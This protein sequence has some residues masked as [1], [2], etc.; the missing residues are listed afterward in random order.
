MAALPQLLHLERVGKDYAKLS[1]D[2]QR[3]RLVAD[4]LWGRQPSRHFRALDDVSL[5]L[6]AGE[7]LAI[8]GEN[9]AGKSTLLKIV[10]GVITPTRGSVALQG[11]VSA[12]LELG[13]GFHPEYSG[14]DNIELAATLLGLSPQ[15]IGTKRDEIISFADIGAHI[16]EPIKH[17]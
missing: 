13:S 5:S 12:L 11:R 7:S 3:L 6:S 17:Y 1:R 8:I 9:G 14:M 4:L 10:A 16:D 2:S 15:Q